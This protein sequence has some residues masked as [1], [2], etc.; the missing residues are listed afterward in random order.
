MDAAKEQ[1]GWSAVAWERASYIHMFSHGWEFIVWA[2][3]GGLLAL[4]SLGM[5]PRQCFHLVACAENIT[6]EAGCGVELQDGVARSSALSD[7]TA[8]CMWSHAIGTEIRKRKEHFWWLGKSWNAACLRSLAPSNFDPISTNP[9]SKLQC[10]TCMFALELL[11]LDVS[12][13]KF[14]L[15]VSHLSYA[16]LWKSVSNAF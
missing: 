9:W 3:P 8:K 15:L 14:T 1:S 12:Q 2:L 6:Q 16:C 11:W 13:V 4:L 7:A 10:R 5:G